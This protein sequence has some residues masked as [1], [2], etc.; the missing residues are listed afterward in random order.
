[1]SSAAGPPMLLR[2]RKSKIEK[3]NTQNREQKFKVIRSLVGVPEMG[4]PTSKVQTQLE[5]GYPAAQTREE[6]V[7]LGTEGGDPQ[8]DRQGDE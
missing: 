6:G 7:Q 5:D 3:S 1:M 2:D 4:T 8:D